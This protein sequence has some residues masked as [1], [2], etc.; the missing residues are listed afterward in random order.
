MWQTSSN[1]SYKILLICTQEPSRVGLSGKEEEAEEEGRSKSRI[2]ANKRW[3]WAVK[4]LKYWQWQQGYRRAIG[5]VEHRVCNGLMG[6]VAA[7]HD[8]YCAIV[9]V[10]MCV[11]AWQQIGKFC[12]KIYFNWKCPP[13]AVNTSSMA[14]CSR[15]K[16]ANEL[17]WGMPSISGTWKDRK[18]HKDWDSVW[19]R[20]TE[21]GRALSWA[22][23]KLCC[24]L[25][26]RRLS[27]IFLS[28]AQI[29]LCVAIKFTLEFPLF[30][31]QFY[32]PSPP[33]SSAPLLVSASFLAQGLI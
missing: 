28:F 7:E 16:S 10:R 25:G 19:D 2:E 3:E 4:R 13:R 18:Q 23:F 32:L 33:L 17:Q 6:V 8:T 21:R 14:P 24:F 29:S 26:A 5:R 30:L 15:H 1:V 9:C 20:M 22:A 11:C 27:N 31:L 12:V